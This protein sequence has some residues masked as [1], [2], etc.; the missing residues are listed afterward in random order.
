ML[1]FDLKPP[2]PRHR[3]E[4]MSEMKLL[5]VGDLAVFCFNLLLKNGPE[6]QV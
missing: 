4:R 5:H 6:I 3:F 1:D 2:S